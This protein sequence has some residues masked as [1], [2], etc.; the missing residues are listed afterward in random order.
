M[1]KHQKYIPLTEKDGT[2]SNKFIVITNNAP[3]D[4]TKIRIGNKKVLKARLNDA[5]FFF[6]KDQEKPLE[7]KEIFQQ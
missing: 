6:L 2:L 3:K 7:R 4:T 5:H 1:Q